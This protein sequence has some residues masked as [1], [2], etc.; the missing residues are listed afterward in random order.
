MVPLSTI[1]QTR[2]LE[3]YAIENLRI[4]EL[5]L[6]EHAAIGVAKAIQKRFG[7]VK[8]GNGSAGVLLAGAGNNG[9]D[10]IAAA[11]ILKNNGFQSLTLFLI[12]GS[13]TTPL[14]Q[15]QLEMA[16]KTGVIIEKRMPTP[17]ELQAACW[18]VDGIFGIGLNRAIENGPRKLIQILHTL[19]P[20]KWIVAV[21]I[22]SGLS[23]NTGIPQGIAVRASQTVTFGVPKQGLFTGDAADYTGQIRQVPIQ[24]PKSA[25]IFKPQSFLYTAE[26]A[27]ETLPPR[28]ASGN[29]GDYGHLFIW[30]AEPGKQGASALVAKG[31]LRAG[32]GLVTIVG[33]SGE[34]EGIRSRLGAEIMTRVWEENFEI[35]KPHHAVGVIGPGFGTTSEDWKILE[36]ALKSPIPLVLDADAL[37]LFSQNKERAITLLAKR[38]E[39]FTVLT[40]HPKEAARLLN[41]ETGEIQADRFK[42]IQ[43]LTSEFKVPVILKGRGTLIQAP[44]SPI[45]IVNAGDSGLSKGGTGDLL[46]GIIGS[47]LAQ[48]PRHLEMLPLG[49]YLHGK[50][51][52]W[53]TQ[54]YGHE[55]STIA[56]DI[57]DTLP[58][59][60]RELDCGR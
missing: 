13:P 1:E 32:C 34:I 27:H 38:K 45:V 19:H 15:Q 23:A 46:C 17:Q 6:M 36:G 51:S 30:A 57:A 9:A 18:I 7:K 12:N 44:E 16:E 21:D 24:I 41:C 42:A 53:V 54:A 3:S 56:S 10:A 40:P 39:R 20:K 50:A 52:E 28:K 29:K 14:Q 60:L 25:A 59:V 4:P 35:Q 33:R 55:R 49:V 8:K 5:L 58:K 31:A 2:Q 37:N 48:S 11:R 47:L 26:D 22:P 43:R